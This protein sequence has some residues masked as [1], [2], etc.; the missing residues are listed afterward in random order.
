MERSFGVSFYFRKEPLVG[1]DNIGQNV[2][3]TFSIQ[4]QSV[5]MVQLRKIYVSY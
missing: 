4:A 5:K 2:L 1:G 3:L